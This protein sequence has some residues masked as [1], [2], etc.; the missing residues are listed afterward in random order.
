MSKKKKIGWF[1]W[2][3]ISTILV[4]IIGAFIFFFQLFDLNVRSVLGGEGDGEAQSKKEVSEEKVQEIEEIQ[5]TVGKEHKEIGEY[6]SE[7]HA[8]YNNTTGYGGISN[9]DWDKQV[10]KAEEVSKF[11]AQQS[12]SVKNKTLK[13]DL[14]DIKKLAKSV[15]DQ[16]KT[17]DVRQLHR[18]FHDLDIALNSYNGY[19]KIWNVT[20][21]LE[22]KN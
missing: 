18:H 17:E 4:I 13:A 21:T 15:I 10:S 11:I 3:V 8:F 12:E 5:N 22:S 6:I 2:T 20:K 19:D 16:Q 7:A 9:L 1:G 14:N